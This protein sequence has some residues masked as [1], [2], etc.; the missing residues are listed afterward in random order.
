MFILFFLGNSKFFPICF[1]QIITN[2][3]HVWN[4][5]LNYPLTIILTLTLTSNREEYDDDKNFEFRL[6]SLLGAYAIYEDKER[7]IMFYA[8]S[9]DLTGNVTWSPRVLL[10]RT[11]N[12][13]ELVHHTTPD[14]G[15]FSFSI[16]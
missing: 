10:M 2:N 13:N 1:L 15:F 4:L 8:I 9:S 11:L 16:A 14:L 6:C 5:P 3:P 7:F 12:A